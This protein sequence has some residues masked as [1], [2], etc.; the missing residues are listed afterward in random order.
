MIRPLALLAL[1]SCAAPADAS[2]RRASASDRFD[3]TWTVVILTEAGTCDRATRYPVRIEGGQAR[4][5][6]TPV[7]IEGRV[8]ADGA[9][10]GSISNGLATARILGRLA[11]RGVGRG[12]WI[13]TGALDCRGRWT[14]ERRG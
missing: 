13:A 11:R 3:G 6:G 14:A 5:V 2:E 12:T 9:V 7:A 1:A 10:A 8:T 4:I